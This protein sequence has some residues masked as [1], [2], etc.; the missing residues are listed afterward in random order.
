MLNAQYSL[1]KQYY[2][3]NALISLVY[4]MHQRTFDFKTHPVKTPINL[5]ISG[6]DNF[7]D[8]KILINETAVKNPY[9]YMG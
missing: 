4:I 1:T 3:I 2:N 6:F 7:V 5:W 9:D 8:W